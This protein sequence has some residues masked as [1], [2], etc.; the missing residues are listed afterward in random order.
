MNFARIHIWPVLLMLAAAILW[1]CGDDL[2]DLVDDTASKS[3]Y[4]EADSVANRFELKGKSSM[5]VFESAGW[6][7]LS[8]EAVSVD[9]NLLPL[10]T[11][12]VFV[13]RT[14]GSTWLTITEW[15][16]TSA[17]VQLNFTCSGLDTLSQMKFTQYVNMNLS[18]IRPLDMIGALGSERLRYLVQEDGFYFT[19][20]REKVSREVDRLLERADQNWLFI[21]CQTSRSDSAF[22]RTFEDMSR[23]LGSEKTWRDFTSEMAVADELVRMSDSRNDEE[24]AEIKRLAELYEGMWRRAYGFGICDTTT[25]GDS[26]LLEDSTSQWYLKS[27]VCYDLYRDSVPRWWISSLVPIVVNG[28]TLPPAQ[29]I[30]DWDEALNRVVI[31]SV[32]TCTGA[33]DSARV[34]VNSAYYICNNSAWNPISREEYFLGICD[35]TSGNVLAGQYARHDS[36]G[37]FYCNRSWSRILAPVYY[38][39]TVKENR[40]VEYDGVYFTS[41]KYGWSVSTETEIKERV[42]EGIICDDRTSNMQKKVNDTLYNVCEKN[43]WNSV[44]FDGERR[45]VNGLMEKYG[46]D[47]SACYGDFTGESLV[48]LEEEATLLGCC[49][50]RSYGYNFWRFHVDVEGFTGEELAQGR[51][52]EGRNKNYLI[53]KDGVDYVLRVGSSTYGSPEG[54][55]ASCNLNMSGYVLDSVTYGAYVADGYVVGYRDAGSGR[56]DASTVVSMLFRSDSYDEFYGDLLGRLADDNRCYPWPS[57]KCSDTLQNP[58]ASQVLISD[59]PHI[60]YQ[61]WEQAQTRCPR[62]FHIPDTTEWKS[63]RLDK[64]SYYPRSAPIVERFGC[65]ANGSICR[66]SHYDI[67]WSS[68]AKDDDT[69]YCIE[70]GWNADVQYIVSRVIECPR[71]LFPL[72][73]TMCV[74]NL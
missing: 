48:W 65:N 13:R 33:R 16:S 66:E 25:V 34:R 52:S 9:D 30:L 2:E 43:K 71:D 59:E 23:S 74:K 57:A 7:V 35:T 46:L 73:Q 44:K 24:R 1:G 26:L 63:I 15:S 38:R 4:D 29:E 72:V 22:Y 42:F 28:D 36:V 6:T 58:A 47:E 17:L 61:T 12:E 3:R 27:F 18:E 50:S 8:V 40:M 64:G 31:D 70:L 39:D 37:Y 10:D 45:L 60:A 14:A 69:Q 51:F 62:G 41:S 21:V 20:A 67:V 32:G 54:E 11:L 56:K 55:H 19:L 5:A 53:T 68:T 49:R